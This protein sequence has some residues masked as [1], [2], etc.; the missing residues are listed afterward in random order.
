VIPSPWISSPPA[1]DLLGAVRPP[2]RSTRSE[3]KATS[4]A[5][6]SRSSCSPSSPYVRSPSTQDTEPSRVRDRRTACIPS[7]G[8]AAIPVLCTQRLVLWRNPSGRQTLTA[9][10]DLLT[11]WVG[12]SSA[13]VT[14][15]LC[16]IALLHVAT[17]TILGL[18]LMGRRAYRSRLRSPCPDPPVSMP[19]PE[20]TWDR[21]VRPRLWIGKTRV[22]SRG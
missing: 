16:G 17:S 12:L 10:H 18:Q 3:R 2:H 15:Y 13:L 5:R 22:W 8:Y 14:L 1:H 20:V 9:T 6:R 4:R 11:S 21:K 7:Q 19:V